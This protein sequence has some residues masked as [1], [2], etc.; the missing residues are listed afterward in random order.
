[1]NRQNK[2]MLKFCNA[3]KN[4]WCSWGVSQRN[5]RR[6]WDDMRDYSCLF[7]CAAQRGGEEGVQLQ[8]L[9]TFG[10]CCW[11]LSDEFTRYTRRSPPNSRVL[12][13]DSAANYSC[14]KTRLMHNFV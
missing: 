14:L 6:R 8:I 7:I 13:M 5:R 12:Q 3:K 4:Q 2:Y 9:F 10:R 11:I 1:M